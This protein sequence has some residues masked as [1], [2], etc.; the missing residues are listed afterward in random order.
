MIIETELANQQKIKLKHAKNYT[1]NTP[2]DYINVAM[3][4]EHIH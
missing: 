4:I 3:A 1:N 2:I